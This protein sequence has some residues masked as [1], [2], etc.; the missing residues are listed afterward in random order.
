M[1]KIKQINYD[2][3][4]QDLEYFLQNCGKSKDTF[5][6]FEKR[7]IEIIKSHLVN[8][9]AFDKN[10][11]IGYTHLERENDIVWFGIC[12]DEK[13]HGRGIGKGLMSKIIEHSQILELSDIHLSVYKDNISAIK[14]YEK[15]NFV[16]YKQNEKSYFMKLENKNG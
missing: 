12:I 2:N 1:I 11:P 4:K 16:G 13:Y 7:P 8:Y 15:M 6:Y 14:L 9:M 5:T 10:I 3:N